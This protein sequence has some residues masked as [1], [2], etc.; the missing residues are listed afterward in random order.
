MAMI[1]DAAMGFD[2]SVVG[3]G[4]VKRQLQTL[5]PEI[6]EALEIVI[7]KDTGSIL[8]RARALASGG[9]MQERTGKYV[10]SMK[11]QVRSD[12]R[13]VYGKV[14]S[15]D[16]RSSLFEWGGST[17][18]RDILPN[19]AQVM[20]FAGS[21]GE[22]FAKI[23]HRPVVN[24]PARPTINAAFDEAKAPFETIIHDTVADVVRTSGLEHDLA[25]GSR[26]FVIHER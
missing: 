13:G 25:S 24:Y 20:R 22:V 15:D 12:S 4:S 16:P 18:A 21:A 3:V 6:R 1:S 5:T 7:R 2:V 11:S 14:Y 23:V 9:V 19:A 26:S 8:D 17:P 10:R